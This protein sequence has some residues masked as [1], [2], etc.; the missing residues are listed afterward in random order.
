[1]KSK[2]IFLVSLA[3]LV[4]LFG[5]PSASRAAS[6]PEQAYIDGIA[7]HRQSLNLSCEARSAVDVANF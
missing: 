2:I 5:L 1:M 6:L 7:G 3:A 4:T